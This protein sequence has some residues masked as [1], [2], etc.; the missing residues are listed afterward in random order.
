VEG[1]V[2]G[3]TWCQKCVHM[4]INAKMTPVGTVPAIRG[5]RR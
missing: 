4:Y 2:G 5:G 1:G 3:W